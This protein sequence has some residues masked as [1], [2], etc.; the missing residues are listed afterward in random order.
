MDP[1]IFSFGPLTVT[2]YG[3]FVVSGF[4][5]GLWTAGRR[6]SADG[7]SAET[8]ADLGIWLMLSGIAGAR[9]FHVVIYWREEFANAPIWRI[10]AVYQGG[11]VYYG[12]LLGA[13]LATVVYVRRRKLALW[14]LADVLA[15]SI[16]LG[17]ALGR[18]GCWINGCCYGSPT[19]LPWA[20][21]YPAGSLAPEGAIH[22]VQLY[23][24]VLNVGGYGLLAWLYRRRKFPGQVFASY[25]VLYGILRFAAEFFRG[26]YEIRYAG[27]WATRGQLT[28]LLVLAVGLVLYEQRRR[29]SKG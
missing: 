12:G 16:L 28:S 2:W 15:P 24:A 29:A 23:E 1:I 9:L 27:G 7:M 8:V 26:D 5:L 14:P 19:D 17:H 25:L 6:A 20:A 18:I 4:L 10:A 13:C 21:H 11:L 22:P 3:I